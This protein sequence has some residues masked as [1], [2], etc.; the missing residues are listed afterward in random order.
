MAS[1]L[2]GEHLYHNAV[3]DIQVHPRELQVGSEH[4]ALSVSPC[5]PHC[6][7]LLRRSGDG[8]LLIQTDE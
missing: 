3:L 6:E 5:D 4:E 7:S 2:A 1:L 8:V